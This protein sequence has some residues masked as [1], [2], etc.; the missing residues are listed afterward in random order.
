MVLDEARVQPLT[1]QG[2]LSNNLMHAKV[3]YDRSVIFSVS[4]LYPSFKPAS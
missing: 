4:D 2:Q 1:I 3:S